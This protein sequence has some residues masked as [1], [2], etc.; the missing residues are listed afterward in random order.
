MWLAG[1]SPERIDRLVLCNTAA[2]IGTAESWNTRIETVRA[3]GMAAIAVGVTER[4]FSP[5][6]RDRDPALVARTRALLEKTSPLGYAACAAAIRDTDERSRLG[7]IRAPT[8]VV[9]GRLDPA[10]PP[11]DGRF[12]TDS[13]PGARYVELEAAHLSNLEAPEAFTSAVVDFLCGERAG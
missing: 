11:A 13:I 12:L 3:E 7:A 2:R 1:R 5:G 6:L 4:W 9:S 10:T 8:L